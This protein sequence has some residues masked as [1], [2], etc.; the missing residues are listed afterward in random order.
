MYHGSIKGRHDRTHASI[1]G[2][3]TGSEPPQRVV[4]SFFGRRGKTNPFSIRTECR[5][6]VADFTTRQRARF[7][8][9]EFDLVKMVEDFGVGSSIHVRGGGENNRLRVRRPRRLQVVA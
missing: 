4:V 7:S 8:A 9:G 5:L 2:P 3:G 1:P 6:L